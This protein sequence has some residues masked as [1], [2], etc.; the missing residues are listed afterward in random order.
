MKALNFGRLDRFKHSNFLHI[1]VVALSHNLS[2]RMEK[3]ELCEDKF[4]T[5][6]TIVNLTHA[7]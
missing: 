1:I 2:N 3:D 6:K 5:I 4:I 7:M